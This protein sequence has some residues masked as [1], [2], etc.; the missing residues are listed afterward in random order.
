MAFCN[1]LFFPP[2][3]AASNKDILKGIFERYFRVTDNTAC[4]GAQGM[5]EN[6]TGTTPRRQ[7]P[8]STERMELV[9]GDPVTDVCSVAVSAQTE[10]TVIRETRDLTRDEK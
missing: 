8:E 9:Q 3:A 6:G 4:C 2:C 7:E 1:S 10:L 5:D